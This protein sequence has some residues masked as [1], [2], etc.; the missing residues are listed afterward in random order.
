ME[1]S[2]RRA[3]LIFTPL[4]ATLDRHGALRLAMTKGKALIFSTFI[5]SD[6]R[7]RGNPGS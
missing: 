6:R 4:Q 5:A 3:F 1:R 7:E 2:I